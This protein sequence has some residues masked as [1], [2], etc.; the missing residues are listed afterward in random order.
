[1]NHHIDLRDLRLIR[2]LADNGSITA[3]AKQLHVTQSAASQRLASLQRRFELPLFE[4]TDDGFAITA[5]GQVLYAAAQR[6]DQTLFQAF[7]QLHRLGA[8][9]HGRLRV[10]TQCYTCYRWLPAVIAS[11]QQRLPQMEIEVVAEATD[12]P[13]QALRGDRI[14]LAIVSDEALPE[15]YDYAPLFD[16]EFYAVLAND[17]PL[18]GQQSV[19]PV[20]FAEQNVIVY[21]GRRH[22]IVE[23]VLALAPNGVDHFVEVAFQANVSVDERVLKLG[24]SIASYATNQPNPEIPFWNLAFKNA[25]LYFLGSDD[26]PADAK[27]QAADDLS[28]MLATGW[29]G[30]PVGRVLPLDE[31]ADAHALV[32]RGGQAGRVVLDLTA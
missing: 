26:F 22:A 15:G 21:S 31:I 13:Y 24:G 12:E 4:R 29:G 2:R 16:D 14:D 18:A 8:E 9:G 17:H 11:V 5:A 1:M 7:E 23:R 32:E 3:A 25:R 19:D 20:D 30:Y 10:T 28:E 27:R 6:I